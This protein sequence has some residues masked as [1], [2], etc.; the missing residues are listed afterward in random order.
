MAVRKKLISAMLLALLL[1]LMFVGTAF[2]H[3]D[4][5]GKGTDNAPINPND[6]LLTNGADPKGV[7]LVDLNE[8]K[9]PVCGLHKKNVD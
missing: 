6:A 9:V 1:S 5:D 8:D 2:A 4:P 7:D 3:P